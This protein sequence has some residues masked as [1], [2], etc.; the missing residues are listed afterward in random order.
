VRHASCSTS[1]PTALL[2]PRHCRAAGGK[3]PG[4][5]C[6]CYGPSWPARTP[7]R[8]SPRSLPGLI[9]Y[10]FPSE[11]RRRGRLETGGLV[12]CR[13]VVKGCRLLSRL[14]KPPVSYW[15]NDGQR[16]RVRSGRNELK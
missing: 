15:T 8:T 16:G 10:K 6:T 13:Q 12:G 2:Q 14:A 3:E 4:A 11:E 7:W 1:I 9:W 5:S